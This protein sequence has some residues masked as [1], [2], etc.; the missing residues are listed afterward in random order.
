VPEGEN[1]VQ[2]LIY[3]GLNG[4]KAVQGTAAASFFVRCTC[5]AKKDTADGP[6]LRQEGCTQKLNKNN[7]T[8]KPF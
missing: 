3:G 6:T 5:A 4:A 2:L 8:F 1:A 7:I